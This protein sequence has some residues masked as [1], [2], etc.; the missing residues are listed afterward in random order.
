MTETA[1]R[2]IFG[3]RFVRILWRLG[4]IYWRAPGAGVGFA[5]LAGAMGLELAM[6]YGNFLISDAERTVFDALEMKSAPAFFAS[7]GLLA[8]AMAAFVLASTLRIWLRQLLE[9]RWREGVTRAYVE[10][11]MGPRAFC[12][13]EM[14]R[15]Q[16][17]N[18]DQRIAEDVRD[19]VASALGLSLSLLQAVGTLVSFG[20]LLW[21]LSRQVPLHLRGAELQVPGGMLWVALLWAVATTWL[22]HR[23]GRR[24][25]RINFDKLR[26]EAD[27]RF[28]LI[29]FREN[30]ESVALSRGE[31]V[32]QRSALERFG[33]VM[34]NWWKL[35]AAQRNLSFLTN[36]IGQ[37]SSLV[38]LIVAAPA[39]LGGH[40]TLGDLAQ[41]RFAYG[42]VAGALAWFV[43]AYQ[44]IAR[45]RANI[46]RLAT[47][48]EMMDDT[49]RELAE[50][51]IR[52]VSAGSETL[53]LSALEL[54]ARD[55]TPLMQP[56]NAAIRCGDRVA[57]T[58]PSGA[59]KTT[60]LRAIAGIWPFGH[61]RI[62]VPSR[63]R[64]FFLPQRPYFPLGTLRAVVS[65]PAAEGIFPDAR[66]REV[67]RLL[68]LELLEDRLDRHEIWDESLSAQEQQRLAI[69]RVLLH[70][71]EWLFLD[72]ATSAL[73]E[74]TERRVYE[75]LRERLPE[76]TV[77]TV[78]QRP[79]L[80]AY[81][82][83]RWHLAVADHGPSTLEA[84]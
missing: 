68:G 21:A 82:E 27:F 30:V 6:V 58:G 10:R 65:Y 13:A 19:F 50:G 47:F 42:Q 84:A 7:L 2:P 62:E 35:I 53:R 51:G 33:R 54:V 81:H 12:Q 37:A 38:P 25:V 61:G 36:G 24:L 75:L 31:V 18:P 74:A 78:A 69:A 26:F 41:V 14:H 80:E 22:T 44:E 28:G 11:W 1:E 83:R 63:G 8:A 16:L 48:A 76:T 64:M 56:A 43:N 29:R 39:Y 59:G 49:D 55:G 70:E 73:D 9:V 77:V 46:E 45:W 4:A 32:E 34:H 67:F 66:V 57:I 23:V 71:P 3:R 60:L 20:G 5:M 52:L 72:K 15:Q 40:L 79:G 17:D